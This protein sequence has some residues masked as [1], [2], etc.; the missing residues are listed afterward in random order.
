MN[1]RRQEAAGFQAWQL[2]SSQRPS[3]RKRSAGLSQQGLALQPGML[4]NGFSADGRVPPTT[5]IPNTNECFLTA[6]CAKAWLYSQLVAFEGSRMR[7]Q[8]LS[9]TL[10]PHLNAPMYH[11]EQFSRHFIIWFIVA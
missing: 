8:D 4:P 11:T 6:A 1:A 9:S 7:T 10:C 2:H 3:V 5:P